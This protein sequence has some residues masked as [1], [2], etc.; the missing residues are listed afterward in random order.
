MSA[1][2]TVAEAV[3]YWDR[4]NTQEDEYS[5]TIFLER[6]AAEVLRKAADEIVAACHD[7]YDPGNEGICPIDAIG[8]A[9]MLRD[10][11][12]ACPSGAP[13]S[14]C[15]CIARSPE[16]YDG[17]LEDCPR[18]GRAAEAAAPDPAV[19]LNPTGRPRR[20]SASTRR[21]KAKGQAPAAEPCPCCDFGNHTEYC[22]CD[23][24][25][26]CHPENHAKPVS[27]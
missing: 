20:S 15:P 3:A 13:Q 22:D 17:P 19:G 10:L 25:R 14:E 24:S 16:D 4:Y 11:A 1:P 6:F 5:L 8:A 2:R 7:A 21:R 27:P 18:H 9:N 23:G 26:C 12:A